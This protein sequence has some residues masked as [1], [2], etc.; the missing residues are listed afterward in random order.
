MAE[1][2][3]LPPSPCLRQVQALEDIWVITR[4]VALVEL[5]A[6]DLPVN[7]C[8]SISLE[9][10]VEDRIDALGGAVMML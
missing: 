6:I 5:A 3:G 4:S 8:I 9:R 7:I 1:R 10:Q 2:I